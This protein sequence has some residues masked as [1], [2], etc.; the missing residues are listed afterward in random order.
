MLSEGNAVQFGDL[1]SHSKY[2]M[3]GVSDCIRGVFMGGHPSSVNTISYITIATQGD[4]VD[5]GDLNTGVT[6][7]DG[8]STGHGG[9]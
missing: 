4:S 2:N 8:M 9:L 1:I 7:D 6:T 3:G 5:F